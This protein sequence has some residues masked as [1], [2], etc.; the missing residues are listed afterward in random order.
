[1]RN[2]LILGGACEFCEVYEAERMLN[3]Q[4]VIVDMTVMGDDKPPRLTQIKKLI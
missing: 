2:A 1:M 3:C 4:N